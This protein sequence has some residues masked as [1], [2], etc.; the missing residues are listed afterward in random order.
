MS[1]LASG[2]A[3]NLANAVANLDPTRTASAIFSIA[4][5][6]H[7][8]YGQ[9][10][11][12]QEFCLVLK[13][14][15]DRIDKIVK[16]LCTTK[17]MGAC[18]ENLVA[19]EKCLTE[20]LVL[21]QS[22]GKKKDWKEKAISL[23]S[24]SEN[25]ASIT[26]LT[27][28]LRSIVADLTLAL[29]GKNSNA[30][31]DAFD[32]LKTRFD[33]K[34]SLPV[35][36]EM[37]RIAQEHLKDKHVL[38]RL[39]ELFMS[40]R[41][42]SKS[43]KTDS[44][45]I[46]NSV[47]SKH[48]EY[49][50]RLA[51][52]DELHVL[53]I[54]NEPV[55]EQK[56]VLEAIDK[57]ISSLALPAIVENRRGSNILNLTD[58]KEKKEKIQ[59]VLTELKTFFREERYI[60]KKAEN[61]VL[62]NEYLA[63]YNEYLATNNRA[64][65]AHRPSE[66][67]HILYVNDE[68]LD[69]E[70]SVK[71]ISKMINRLSQLAPKRKQSEIPGAS[72]ENEKEKILDILGELQDIFSEKRGEGEQNKNFSKYNEHLK[73][74]SC[75]NKKLELIYIEKD[76]K[77]VLVINDETLDAETAFKEIAKMVEALDISTQPVNSPQIDLQINAVDLQMTRNL[78]E[79]IK[80]NNQAEV[81]RLLDPNGKIF[82][83]KAINA[84]DAK[85]GASPLYWAVASGYDHFITP[86]IKAGAD[87]NKPDKD[88][89][90][91]VYAAAQNGYTKA[92]FALKAAGANMD[93]TKLSG[94]TPVFIAAEMG[95]A[96]AI[97]ALHAAG[98][99]VNTPKWDGATPVFIAA[100]KGHSEAIS[101][102]KA[103]G[104]NV[105]TSRH[106]GITP[107]YTAAKRGHEKAIVALK[108]AGANVNT[109][110]DGVTPVY[111]AAQEGHASA[112]TA[113]HAAGANV[114]TPDKDGYT[115]IFIAAQE[116]Q[117]LAITALHAAGANVNIP[118][119]DDR[120][121]IY[122]AAQNG[123]ASAIV[124][125]HAAGANVDTSDTDGVTPICIAAENGHATAVVALL[126]A[127]ANA[128][129]KTKYGTA[130]ELARKG[131]ERAHGE[132]VRL[133]EAHIKKYP[134]GINPEKANKLK[135]IKFLKLLKEGEL[136][137]VEGMLFFMA[138]DKGKGD[139]EAISILKAAG[140]NIMVPDKNG[141]TLVYIAAENGHAAVIA[142]LKAAGAVMD[143]PDKDGRTP[144][145]IAAKNGQASAIVALK[146]AG[147]NVDTPLPDGRTPVYS[148]SAQ[149]HASAIAALYA[150]GANVNTA[151]DDG[152]TPTWIA[153][154]NGYS[155]E[156]VALKTAGA[157]VDTPDTDG[158]TPIC[159]AAKNGHTTAIVALLEAGAN[160][161]I[162]TKRGTALD[163]ARKGKEPGHPDVVRL[164]EA[165]FEQYPNGI[166]PVK[167]INKLV[168]NKFL[169]LL[170]E[171]EIGKAESMIAFMATDKSKGDAEAIS[172]LK[173]AGKN[174]MVPDKNGRTLVYIA[175]ENGHVAVIAALKA[176][177]SAMD[178]PD[179]DGVT[180]VYIAARKGHAEAITALK[181]AGANMNA[182]KPDGATPVYCAAYHGHVEVI[183]ALK[184][185][186]ADV[187]TPMDNT[188]PI[189]IAAQEGHAEAIAAL[190]AAGSDVNAADNDG[191]TPVYLAAQEGHAEAI[192][193][194]K[195]AGANVDAPDNDGKT[196]VFI[197]AKNGHTT[198]IVA[199]LEAGANASI[200]TKRGTALDQARKGKEPGHPDVVRLLEAHFKQY[201]NGIKPVKVINK[202][203]L[204]KFLKLLK[205]GEL[206]KAESMLAFMDDDKGESEAISIL[207]AAGK[208]IMVPDKNG[209]TLVYIA[210][211]NG[212][213]PVI[214]ALKAA[215]TNVNT[216]DNDG[217]TPVYIA[218]A[219]GH[220]V[221]VTALKAAGANVNTAKSDGTTPVYK[222]AE[223]GYAEAI[224][225]LKSAGANVNSP[226]PDGLTPVYA[227]AENG[228]AEAITALKAA[229]ANVNTSGNDGFTPVYIAARK[230][231]AEAITALK[232]AG[233]NM[234]TP[235]DGF[236][237]VYVAAEKG[238]AGT[239]AALHA[240]GANMDTPIKNGDIPIGI[241]A[242]K[243]LVA[244]V[245]ALLEAGADASIKTKFG[246]ALEQAK[247]GKE[248]GHPEILRLLKAHFRQYPNGIKPVMVMNQGLPAKPSS[249][250]E[251]KNPPMLAQFNDFPRPVRGAVSSQSNQ[252]PKQA[253]KGSD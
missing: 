27:D 215:G 217:R 34:D 96:A 233:A 167:V 108:A 24:A 21:I 237:P 62:Y 216:P 100:A 54:N 2:V 41:G 73:K 140:K 94:A 210:A 52:K 231:H 45:D 132:V 16:E 125:L 248:P 69:A 7:E 251:Q 151:A 201:P 227:A 55:S 226:K 154:Q 48:K 194:L 157:N 225:A 202:L 95:H 121:P 152:T 65:L 252:P 13:E 209:R 166:K 169:K 10:K 15:V 81:F 247:Q 4:S 33:R 102:L 26:K 161:S 155:E 113:L 129:I 214:T 76:H 11:S 17:Q 243:G 235:V 112:I 123:Q 61:Y 241:A 163:Q 38:E 159:V 249:S 28:K 80:Q 173:A 245:A 59:Y 53:Y 107:V 198:A 40:G 228:Y 250:T 9:M 68:P 93:I 116:G 180:P 79:V 153:A 239:I 212:H 74:V 193:A 106:D 221:A 156:I 191:V 234:D 229:G 242:E 146:T 168:L 83:K 189:Q 130:L 39:K 117:A 72:V 183:A 164:L 104:A 84:V 12:N 213:V 131:N 60:G 114:N 172:L 36:T 42:G 56:T 89:R 218:A 222:A 145:Y 224:A 158:V 70:D 175:A 128:S 244:V 220:A 160:A 71:E 18:E 23:F 144:V 232:A 6:I 86:L 178:M 5:K 199:L 148:A 47:L 182:P 109:L 63:T 92:I 31:A 91:P 75:E 51:Y 253:W 170:T 85:E 204:N 165:H 22:I 111:I 137:K 122:I 142:A 99:N 141:R 196:P 190:K 3:S 82:G 246:T 223:N 133:L 29:T 120:T 149:G 49:N 88:G 110:C 176:A 124:A 139:A 58:K 66:N 203:V 90:T 208:N 181:A 98:A 32:D 207:R 118:D 35:E 78:I 97:T 105:D 147:A 192:S 236:T 211:E 195:A 177:G 197:A 187:N 136:E 8:Q 238:H 230:G 1:T 126:E 185:A 64:E 186:G 200:K 67:K 46:Y 25:K 57:M 179:N 205:K 162:K 188:T 37:L 127:G 115:P 174:I 87:V 219:M 206:D 134:N 103:S 30:N 184:A 138:T 43:K 101:A 77:H 135:L 20:C 171:G 240:A 14:E 19:L 143:I 44:M 119:K 50:A 150:A